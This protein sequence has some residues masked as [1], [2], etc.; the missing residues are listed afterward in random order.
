MAFDKR[1]NIAISRPTDLQ[2][3]L[4]DYNVP[5]T[6]KAPIVFALTVACSWGL[7]R[8]LRMIPGANKVL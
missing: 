1:C 3:W 5:A 7:T 4:Y 2:Y 8:A 6:V